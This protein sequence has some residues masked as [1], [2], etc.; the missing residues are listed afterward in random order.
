M[1]DEWKLIVEMDVVVDDLM[2]VVV[3]CM[4]VVMECSMVVDPEVDCQQCHS[5]A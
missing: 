5:L 4:V 3:E 2:V 1:V